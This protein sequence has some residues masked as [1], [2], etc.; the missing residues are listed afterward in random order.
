MIR[1]APLADWLREA[2]ENVGMSQ[3]QVAQELGYSSPQFISNWERGLASPPIPKFKKLC[4]MYN[5]S[6]HDAYDRL[7]Q[8]TLTE[9]ERKLH[10]DFFSKSKAKK[11]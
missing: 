6:I 11:H 4:K 2:R 1:K 9:V 10:S 5:L 8:A 3:G 7:L